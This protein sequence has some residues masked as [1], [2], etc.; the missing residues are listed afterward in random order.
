MMELTWNAK[1]LFVTLMFRLL[2]GGYVVAMD[3]YQFNDLDS[4]L[5]VV[6]IYALIAVFASLFLFG[7]KVGLIGVIGLEAVFLVL[8][9]VFLVLTLG[10]IADPGMHDPLANWWTTL[11][12][13]IFSI[14]T[15]VFSVR[16]YRETEHGY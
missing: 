7:K 4:A 13:Y 5:T 8:N 16:T 1:A 12:R 6:V 3:Q 10:Q 14:L 9:S 11:L 15:L 2:F